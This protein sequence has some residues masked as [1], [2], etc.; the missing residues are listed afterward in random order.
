LGYHY[1][2]KAIQSQ[3]D[4]A[5]RDAEI[6]RQKIAIAQHE[7]EM[8]KKDLQI[9]VLAKEKAQAQTAFL[10]AQINPHFMYNTLNMIFERVRKTSRE[11]GDIVLAFADMMRYATSAKSQED[12]VPLYGEL[13]FVEQYI[14]LHLQRFQHKV[15]ID[16]HE[17][18]D[19]NSH[20][21][22]PMVLITL[23]ENGIKHGLFD[24]PDFPFKIRVSLIDDMFVFLTN[25]LKNPY[26][27][28]IPDT[29]QTGIGIENIK[30][31]LK[32]TFSEDAYDFEIIETDDDYTVIFTI[33]FKLLTK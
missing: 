17:E 22:V 6:A 7:A 21:I 10:R 27:S 24:N 4:L 15:Y 11:V 5:L 29:G 33:N 13:R 9:A 23:V 19:F 14:E 12:L 1:A 3:K 16:Y 28:S 32:G 8:A 18:G 25:N 31:R 20:Q 30:H 2:Q 26:P